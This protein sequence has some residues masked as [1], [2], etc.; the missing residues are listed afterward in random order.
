MSRTLDF[1]G[2]GCHTSSLHFITCTWGLLRDTTAV[3]GC[4]NQGVH[5]KCPDAQPPQLSSHTGAAVQTI[6]RHPGADD[7]FRCGDSGLL[8][9][10]LSAQ[11]L[12]Q[13]GIQ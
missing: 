3:G 6:G 9:S 4:R 13:S 5:G 11:C 12:A 8:C 7:L 2:R 1:G 10:L